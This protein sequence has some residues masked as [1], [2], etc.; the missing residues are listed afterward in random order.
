MNYASI[1]IE[2]AILS[3]DILERIE[4]AARQQAA[5]RDVTCLLC[6]MIVKMQ[7]AK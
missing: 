6:I 3:P 7:I 4:D 5:D 2:G 1:R